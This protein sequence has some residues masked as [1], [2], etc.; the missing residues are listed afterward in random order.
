MASKSSIKRTVGKAVKG[1]AKVA[2]HLPGPAGIVGKVVG[3]GASL[4]G[5]RSKG[6]GK[7][8]RFSVSKYAKK[9][10]KAKLDAKLMKIKMSPLRGL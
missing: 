6:T 9:I 7:R 3:A 4:L 2:S 1:V 5:G 10:M 8:H